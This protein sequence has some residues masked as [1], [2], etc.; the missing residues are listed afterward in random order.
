MLFLGVQKYLGTVIVYK[1]KLQGK[2]SELTKLQKFTSLPTDKMYLRMFD[3]EK[4]FYETIK[5]LC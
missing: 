5:K 3:L 1:M 2:L 4:S